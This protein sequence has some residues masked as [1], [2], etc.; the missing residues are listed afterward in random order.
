MVRV[1]HIHSLVIESSYAILVDGSMNFP[2]HMSSLFDS[3][4]NLNYLLYEYFEHIPVLIKSL[5]KA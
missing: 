5:Q 4:V 2:C 3:F 1:S